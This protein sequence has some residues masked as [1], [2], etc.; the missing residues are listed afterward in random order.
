M[1]NIIVS[2]KST[3][4]GGQKMSKLSH[5]LNNVSELQ[6]QPFDAKLQRSIEPVVLMPAE[7]RHR[8]L[9][10]RQSRLRALCSGSVGACGPQKIHVSV[11]KLHRK[12]GYV[13]IIYLFIL[14]YLTLL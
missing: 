13:V 1:V 11:E 6:H 8:R 4:L 5:L 10:L 2:A 7:R 14:S 12:K 3:V 9:S